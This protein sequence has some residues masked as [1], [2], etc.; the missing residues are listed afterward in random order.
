MNGTNGAGQ[1]KEIE[2]ELT[3]N[4]F[5]KIRKFI[6]ENRK[7]F[8][9]ARTIFSGTKQFQTSIAKAMEILSMENGFELAKLKT[10][11]KTMK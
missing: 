9:S 1:K 8:I 6:M 2:V 5:L 7:Y 3:K 10:P 4:S 11:V